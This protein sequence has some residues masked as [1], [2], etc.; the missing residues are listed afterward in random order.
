MLKC[1]KVSDDSTFIQKKR[2]PVHSATFCIH[3]FLAYPRNF[4]DTD[5]SPHARWM[6]NYD[7]SGHFAII[8]RRLR[9]P[10]VAAL[11]IAVCV[12]YRR[13]N[14]CRSLLFGTK[15]RWST[16]TF[17]IEWLHDFAE[18]LRIVIASKESADVHI[19]QL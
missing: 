10:T 18:R 14:A 6:I 4:P 13:N 3:V 11:T 9:A 8:P 19:R 5:P 16:A 7:Y 2:S 12:H 1:T 15:V 17:D